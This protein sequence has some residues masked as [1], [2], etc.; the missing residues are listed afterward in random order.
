MDS[1][2]I[3]I[4]L[5]ISTAAIIVAVIVMYPT[6]SCMNQLNSGGNESGFMCITGP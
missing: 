6:Y 2:L 4:A 3:K 1:V 5:I